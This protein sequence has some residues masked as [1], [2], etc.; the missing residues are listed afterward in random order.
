[1]A[2]TLDRAPRWDSDAR[3]VGVGDAR[4]HLGL[5]DALRQ[6]ADERD[7]VAEE[8]W[9]HLLP[10]LLRHV[11]ETPL[12]VIDS[13]SI[14]P[15]GTFVVD[16]RWAGPPDADRRTVRA[17]AVGMIGAVAE[18][19]T[20]IH[21]DRGPEGVA[22]DVVTGMLPGESRFASHGHTLRLRVS[23]PIG[24]GPAASTGG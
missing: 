8:P 17:A 2:E 12:L 13:T 3:G 24:Q 5:L 22:Y 15:D 23:Q 11:A 6:A 20:V 9:S 14:A 18:A 1:V 7:W 21:E 4:A 19:T 16:I 10:H